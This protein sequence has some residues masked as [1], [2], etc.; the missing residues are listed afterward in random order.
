MVG[1]TS[2]SIRS[3]GGLAG[4]EGHSTPGHSTPVRGG[5]LLA[6]GRT[7]GRSR[8]LADKAETPSRC[9]CRPEARP[10]SEPGED[11]GFEEE[12]LELRAFERGPAGGGDGQTQVLER[13]PLL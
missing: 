12:P 9:P 4:G 11:V 8:V 2:G 5:Y 6:S 7:G 10:A 13:R 1:L 3:L